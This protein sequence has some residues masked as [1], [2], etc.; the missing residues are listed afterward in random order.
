MNGWPQL[1][2]ALAALHDGTGKDV[3]VAILDSGIETSHP[4]L[5]GLR[6]VDDVAIIEDGLGLATVPGEGRDVFGHGTAIASIIYELAP[7]AQIGSFRVLGSQLR[8]RSLIIREGV[9]QAIARGYH[10]LNCSF[11]CS[12][13]DHILMYK[14]WVDQAYMRGR[15]I[16]AACNNR[17]F[18]T[19]EWPGHFPTVITVNATESA[20]PEA[21]FSRTGHLVEFAARGEN[22]EVAWLGGTCKRV[23]GSSFAVPHLAA[24]L[25]RLIAFFPSLSPLEAKAILLKMATPWA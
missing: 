22:V 5:Q 24:M 14:D 11:G 1:E 25:A 10:I 4:L 16:V 9:R 2:G 7:E 18:T 20:R 6:M 8:S 12:R 21:F 19:R 3:K 15:H 17:S 13:E 23:T